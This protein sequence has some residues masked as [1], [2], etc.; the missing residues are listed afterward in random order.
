MYVGCPLPRLGRCGLYLGLAQGVLSSCAAWP[1]V[2]WSPPIPS[3]QGLSHGCPVGRR[4]HSLNRHGRACPGHPH[5][6]APRCWKLRT[7]PTLPPLFDG[8]PGTYKQ[9]LAHAWL[10]SRKPTTWMAGTSP[11]MTEGGRAVF[12]FPV[13]SRQMTTECPASQQLLRLA[14]NLNRTAVGLRPAMTVERGRLGHQPDSAGR[15]RGGVRRSHP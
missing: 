1:M 4:A 5:R 3:C 11:A 9:A 7:L 15:Y 14:M 6:A 10:H 8:H 13:Q 12:R 2:E